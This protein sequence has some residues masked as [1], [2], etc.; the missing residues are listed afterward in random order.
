[1]KTTL[2]LIAVLL[3]LQNKSVSANVNVSEIVSALFQATFN[4]N[5]FSMEV[6]ISKPL[7]TNETCANELNISV[8]KDIAVAGAYIRQALRIQQTV[9]QENFENLSQ[10]KKELVANINNCVVQN[11]DNICYFSAMQH[12][13]RKIKALNHNQIPV[14]NAQIFFHLEKLSRSLAIEFAKYNVCLLQ[15]PE[16]TSPKP[17]ASSESTASSLSTDSEPPASSLSTEKGSSD[18]SRSEETTAS[19]LLLPQIL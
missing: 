7:S 2:A 14:D 12:T 15:H 13:V 17:Q 18:S 5:G 16:V 4:S 1:M 19:S 11:A 8:R 6:V 9:A 3:V 10:L